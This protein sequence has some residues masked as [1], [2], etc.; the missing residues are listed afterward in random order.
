[1]EPTRLTGQGIRDLNDRGPKKK[2]APA[3]VPGPDSGGEQPVTAAAAEAAK[4]A[5]D[6]PVATSTV[7]EVATTE[8]QDG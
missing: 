6:A 4:E 8:H 1:M 2:P 5:N 7:T 3:E